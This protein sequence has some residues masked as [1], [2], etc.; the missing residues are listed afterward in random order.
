MFFFFNNLCLHFLYNQFIMSEQF[1]W[2]LRY[3]ATN[4]IIY[5]FRCVQVCTIALDVYNIWCIHVCNLIEALFMG[6]CV[7]LVHLMHPLLLLPWPL[8]LSYGE[9]LVTLCS[10]QL[11][12]LFIS[13]IYVVHGHKVSLGEL[14]HL[15]GKDFGRNQGWRKVGTEV[16]SKIMLI[17]SGKG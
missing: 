7:I 17:E 16:N 13:Y 12:A 15:H 1:L 8:A 4:A 11:P 3:L 14:W 10:K 2:V 9:K 5:C 6:L